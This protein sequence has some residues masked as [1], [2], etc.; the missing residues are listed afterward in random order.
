MTDCARFVTESKKA[1]VRKRERKIIAEGEEEKENR[2]KDS[3]H[4]QRAHTRALTHTHTHTHINL[5]LQ[6]KFGA[7]QYQLFCC[8]AVPF[9]N[10]N[11]QCRPPILQAAEDIISTCDCASG[12]TS[13]VELSKFV[14]PTLSP[15]HCLA[16]ALDRFLSINEY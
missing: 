9:L 3:I 10:R 11:H 8:L 12:N 13:C 1:R 6:V 16:L 15:F 14:A 5:V 7:G 4:L 2:K